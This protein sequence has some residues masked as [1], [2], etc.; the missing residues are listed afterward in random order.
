MLGRASG[1]T[2]QWIQPWI[3]GEQPEHKD[4]IC[5]NPEKKRFVEVRWIRDETIDLNTDKL[6][7]VKHNVEIHVPSGVPQNQIQ[8]PY[9]PPKIDTSIGRP[10]L[11]ALYD[12]PGNGVDELAFRAGDIIFIIQEELDGRIYHIISH[13]IIS[14]HIISH[15]I[16]PS[17]DM[18]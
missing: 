12:C 1:I 10:S 15:H 9:R 18:T 5:V 3:K 14:H 6:V 16:T 4:T 7:R 2:I 8:A 13:H 11:K 17:H